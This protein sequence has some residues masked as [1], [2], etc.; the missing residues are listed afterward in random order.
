MYEPQRQKTGRNHPRGASSG[1]HWH[2]ETR[3][4]SQCPSND[5][6]RLEQGEIA[7]PDPTLLMELGQELDLPLIELYDLAGIPTPSLRPYL[8][9]KYGLVRMRSTRSRKTS[10]ESQH[11]TVPPAAAR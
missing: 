4:T 5:A 6:I 1:G 10:S 9:A 3:P 8:R 7:R 11:A 2:T